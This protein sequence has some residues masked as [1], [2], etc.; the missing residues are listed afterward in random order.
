MKAYDRLSL[1]RIFENYVHI[2]PYRFTATR[3]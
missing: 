1:K 2:L 3:Y